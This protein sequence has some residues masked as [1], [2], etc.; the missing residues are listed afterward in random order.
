MMPTRRR[1]SAAVALAIVGVVAGSWWAVDRLADGR[2]CD[3]GRGVRIDLACVDSD[4]RRLDTRSDG[5]DDLGLLVGFDRLRS[6]TIDLDDLDGDLSGLEALTGLD[7]LAIEGTGQEVDLAPLG[8]LSRLE[9]LE[10][11]RVDVGDLADLTL[12]SL[13]ELQATDLVIEGFPAMPVVVAIELWSPVGAGVPD[14][15]SA[16]QLRQL[17]LRRVGPVDT[18]GLADL[19][20]LERLWIDAEVDG[21]LG[22]DDLGFVSGMANLEH[23]EIDGRSLATDLRPLADLP[24]RSLVLGEVPVASLQPLAHVVTLEELV[25]DQAPVANLEPLSA[26][27]NLRS[28]RLSDTKVSSLEH[29]EGLVALEHLT[30]YASPIDD[31]RPVAGLTNLVSLS[32]DRSQ[33][34]DLTPLADLTRLTRLSLWGTPVTDLSGIEGLPLVSIDLN[35]SSLLSVEPL[36]GTTTLESLRIGFTGVTDLSPLENLPVLEYLIPPEGDGATDRDAVVTLLSGEEL[37]GG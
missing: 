2:S 8:A 25:I 30:V 36:A 18:D 34:S 4:A 29:I 22:I 7:S 24:L 1:R 16:P 26:L 12:P 3:D 6:L 9:Q 15:T 5:I 28:L 35:S 37:S 21:R 14:A 19:V 31:L 17:G 13:I 20:G 10:L 11:T 23:L 32:L 33:V 27:V